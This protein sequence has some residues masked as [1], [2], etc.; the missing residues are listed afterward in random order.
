MKIVAIMGSPR[1]GN[2]YRVTQQIE[3]SIKESGAVEFT[4]LFLKDMNLKRCPGCFSCIRK[5]EQFCPLKDDKDIILEQIL[6]AN[7]VILASPSYNFNVTSIMKN[8]IDRFAYIGHQ[9][10]FF[11]QHV[12][13]VATTAG[14]GVKEVITYLTKYVAKLWGFRSVTSIGLMTPPYEKAA[15]LIKK[16][17]KKIKKVSKEFFNKIKTQAWSPEYYHIEQFCFLRAIFSID[18]MKDAFPSDYKLYKSLENKKFY[19][20]AK[21]NFFKYGIARILSRLIQPFIKRSIRGSTDR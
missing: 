9:P 13:I 18:E 11:N 4:Y 6:N 1:K 3:E 17:N 5:G 2:T 7:G 21:V 19:I 14:T 15:N 12:M 8:F 20:P 16:D 10:Q